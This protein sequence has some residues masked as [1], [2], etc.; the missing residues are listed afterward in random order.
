M[1]DLIKRVAEL[2][3]RGQACALVTVISV[4]RS[5]PREL[6]AKMIVFPDGKIE[7]TIGGGVLEA[8]AIQEAKMAIAERKSRKA[9]FRLNPEEV[10]MYCGGEVEIFIDV[11]VS[12]IRLLIL[13]GGHVAEKI[14]ALASEIGVPYIV[15][16]DRAEFANKERFSKAQEILVGEPQYLI[17]KVSPPVD[18]KTYIIIVTHCHGFDME[19]LAESLKTKAA[20][21]GLIGSRSKIKASYEIL[22]KQGLRPAEDPR[23]HAPIGLDLGDKSPGGIAVSIIAEI[24]KL[25][26]G[27]TGQHMRL[28]LKKDTVLPKNSL[29]QG[30]SPSAG[31]LSKLKSV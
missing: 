9:S 19:C 7:G 5:T 21:I 12:G 23:V 1:M 8:M 6:G 15:A 20:Y 4:E 14:G 3:D 11:F 18:E 16:D 13:G 2:K 22:E 17:S 10:G 25:K 26:N 31:S 29:P 28:A 24:L 27:S 30:R